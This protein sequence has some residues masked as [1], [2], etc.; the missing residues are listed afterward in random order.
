MSTDVFQFEQFEAFSPMTV[1]GPYRAADY[2]KL[3]EGERVE[4]IRGRLIMSPS[5]TPLHQIVILRLARVL[6]R[7]EEIASGLMLISPMDVIFSDDTILQ[8]DLLYISKNR[9]GIVG[10][11]I[12]GAPDLVVEVLSRGTSRRDKTEKLDLYAKYGVP[13]YWMVDPASQ[14][15]EFLL[16]D[17]GRYV[18]TQPSDNRYQSPRLSEVEIDLAAFW[19]EV[20]RRTAN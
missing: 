6:E 15:I 14:V 8:P 10:E 20:I 3:P 11:R 18:M 12:T 2:W 1:V 17:Q 19:A 4:L 16:L 7:A 13:E 9:R 5:P